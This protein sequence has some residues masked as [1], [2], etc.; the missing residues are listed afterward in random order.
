VKNGNQMM[1]R[2]LILNINDLNSGYGGQATFIKNLHPYLS[3]AFE[4]KYL[5]VPEFFTKHHKIPLRLIYLIQVLFF[6]IVKGNRY[7]LIISHTPEASFVASLFK[8]KFIHIFHGNNNAMTKSIFWY[9]KYF[10]RLF[11]FFDKRIIQKA[12]K[13]YTVGE[14]RKEAEK[15][16]NPINLNAPKLLTF[17]ERSDFV[18]AGRLES[19]KNIDS[20]I[21]VY[22]LLPEKIKLK[23][24]LLIVGTGTQEKKLKGLVDRMELN[25]KVVFYGQ[26]DNEHTIDII[27]RSLMLLMSSSY[28]G[29]PMVIAESLTVGTPVISTD[30][31]DIGSIIRSGYNGFLLP[32]NYDK[33]LF[34]E[35][36]SEIISD[37]PVF[38]KNASE[39]SAV[40][41]AEE[42]ASKFI[43]E[44]KEI[45]GTGSLDT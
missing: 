24:K 13:L 22:N 7:I 35:N 28:E 17:A 1:D 19:M 15:F 40:F 3:N 27:S 14:Y 5:V 4:L 41:S 44:C 16:Y 33:S 30:V 32:L 2:V 37:Y 12:T 20:I 38:T 36:I 34:V 26:L 9:G 25:D 18:F 23:N 42:I 21:E 43:S 10:K 39:S 8:R 45:I 29:F 31:G 6:M 11:E